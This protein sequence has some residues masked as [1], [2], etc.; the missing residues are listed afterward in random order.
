MKNDANKLGIILEAS[1]L[2]NS[3]QDIDYI[4]NF[5]L[6]KSLEI[7]QNSDT[8]IIFLYDK[9]LDVLIPKFH[10]GF[11]E[12]IQNIRLSPGE[13][14]TGLAFSQKETVFLTKIYDINVT[15]S[16]MKPEN[17]LLINESL[18]TKSEL[19]STICCPLIYR[20]EC[21]GVIVIDNFENQ[22][23]FTKADVDCLEAISA[24]A[25]VAINNAKNYTKELQNIT[26]L[27]KYNKML[28]DEKNKYKYSTYLHNKFSS[29]VLNGCSIDDLIADLSLLIKKDVFVIDLFYN[30]ASSNFEYH[31]NCD[32]LNYNLKDIYS[33]LNSSSDTRWYDSNLSMYYLFYPIIVNLDTLGWLCIVSKDY[34]LS[35]LDNITVEKCITSIA[36][37]H[38]KLNELSDLEQTLKGDFLDS[39]LNNNDKRFLN[40]CFKKYKFD[41]N[42][43]CQMIMFEISALCSK[44]DKNDRKRY[45]R[46]IKYYYKIITIKSKKYFSNSIVFIKNDNI[47]IIYKIDSK[48]RSIIEKFLEELN[49]E[50]NSMFLSKYENIVL[51]AGISNIIE[52]LDNF[53]QSYN[54]T[55]QALN[56]AK[57]TKNILHYLFYEDLEIKKFLLSNDLDELKDFVDR[58]LGNL[59]NYKKVSKN[60]FMKTLEVYIRSNGSWTYTKDLLHIHGNTLSYRLN[61]IMKILDVNLDNYKQRLKLQIAFEIL[62]LL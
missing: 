59:I 43:K 46:L 19:K 62:D 5:L 14:M 11:H 37:E 58:T 36:L 48:D 33:H 42:Y 60:E 26:K 61:K 21:I 41:F 7:I 9:D 55:I 47:I 1:K 35:E 39:L 27:E 51:K 31:I 52:C 20:D 49:N 10:L 34:D 23:V 28:E 54:N 25:A 24:Q 2:L 4:L 15:M 3:T 16:N 22:S 32:I 29:M 38:L 53:N 30:M 45:I 13:S 44:R 40:K 8:G 56:M 12:S 50:R 6:K 57:N 18:Q 17:K